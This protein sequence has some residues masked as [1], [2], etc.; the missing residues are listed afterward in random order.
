VNTGLP[1]D[2]ALPALRA[3]LQRT[4]CAVLQAPP[5]AGKSTVV[6]LA[7]LDEPWMRGRKL[8]MLEPRRLAARA[9]AARMAESLSETVGRTVGYR[10]RLDTRVS[11]A[12]RIE[13][14]TEGVLTRMLQH[15]P[16]LEGVGAVVFDEFHER[17]LPAD[18]GLALTLD[19]QAN[20]TPELR[21]LVM[22]ATLDT[23]GIAKLLGDAPIVSAAGRAFPVTTHYVG[24]GAPTLP[25]DPDPPERMVVRAVKRALRET[26]GDM[27]VFLPGAGEIRR[28]QSMLVSD[29]SLAVLQVLPLYGELSAADQDAALAH[30]VPGR[31]KCVL[32]TNI[33]ETSLTIDGVTVVVDSGLARRSMFDPASGMNRLETRRTSRASADQRQGRAGRTAPGTCYRLWSEGAQRSLAAFTPPEIVEADLAPLALDLAAWG[34]AESELRWLDA[35]PA[36]MLASARGLLRSL[37]ALAGDGRLTPHGRAM[38]ELAVHP[39][40]AHMLLVAER[41]GQ[42]EEAAWLAAL[43]SERDLL[44]AGGGAAA[45]GRDSDLRT[46]LDALRGAGAAGVDRAALDRV[47]RMVRTLRA[48]RSGGGDSGTANPPA[49][50]HDSAGMLLASAYP[51]RIGRRRD[52]AEARYQLSNGRGAIFAAA[53]SIAREEFIVALDLDD[54]EREARVRLAAPIRRADLLAWARNRATTRDEVQWDERQQAVVSRR[55]V[56]LDALVLEERPLA[57]P[58]TEAT[59][60]AMLAG[61]RSMGL[62]ALP[63]NADAQAL[64]SRIAFVATLGRSDLGAWPRVDDA[65]LA[66]DL[67]WLEPHLSGISRRTQLARLPL[68]VALRAMLDFAQQRKL[69]ELA[70]THVALPTG[71][72]ARIDYDD[73]SAPCAS[74]RMQEVFGLAATPRI[75]GGAVPIT[76]KL[77]SP[78]QRPLQITRDLASFWRDAYVNVRKDMRGRY[79]RHYWPEDPLQA[80]PT[81]RAKPRS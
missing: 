51:D 26:V 77:L 15:D 30:A 34:T 60:A 7:L 36:A 42:R 58:P 63:W 38:S 61:L 39:R 76:F 46:R 29:E 75:G 56:A 50:L 54:R 1:I 55:I 11:G 40:L 5:G 80:E 65:T 24:T 47:R 66:S 12:T 52:G 19:A 41:V 64:R 45:A 32:A 43:L 62:A 22:S 78:A 3:A 13:V 48:N 10:M 37:G 74:M 8:L 33:A 68:E 44:R 69:D 17:S 53:E 73:E 28:V 4:T 67:A 70:P 27:L 59:R 9:V 79:P 16:A 35:P 6:P 31:R 23:S 14:V 20:L 18:L 21:V 57:D 72:R 2:S 49:A 71:T 81:R 25:G